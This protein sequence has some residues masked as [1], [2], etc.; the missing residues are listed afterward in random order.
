[1]RHPILLGYL[2]AAL[3]SAHAD[4]TIVNEI[5]SQGQKQEMTMKIKGK[6]ALVQV[7]DQMSVLLNGATGDST[8]LLHQQK[9]AMIIPGAS[10]QA[11]LA[12][13]TQAPGTSAPPEP[14]PAPPPVLQP[15]G[16]TEA[17]AG[18]KTEGYE[19]TQGNM[20]AE[21]FLAKDFPDLAATLAQLQ[22]FQQ[23][24]VNRLA[25]AAAKID[26]ASFPGF[27]V[28]TIVETDGQKVVSTVKSISRDELPSSVFQLPAD[29]QKM[30]LPLMPKAQP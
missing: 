4:L 26:M 2:L 14:S 23:S 6:D 18:F 16:K 15:T 5:E 1:M 19:Y 24:G 3:S 17:I 27:P 20:K 11:M 10:M 8:M 28:R 29:Y 9:K 7:N 12:Q 22:A 13:M 25:G 30:D 21:Y